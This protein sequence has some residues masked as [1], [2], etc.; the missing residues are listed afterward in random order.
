MACFTHTVECQRYKE[1]IIWKLYCGKC[2][3]P[4]LKFFPS[5]TQENHE[6]SQ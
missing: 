6:I 3:L 5:V 2:L 4:N 1:I